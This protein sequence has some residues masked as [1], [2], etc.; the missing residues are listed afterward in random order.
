[1]RKSGTGAVS[2]LEGVERAPLRLRFVAGAVDFLVV[3]GVGIVVA[4]ALGYLLVG[5]VA[6]ALAVQGRLVP[7]GTFVGGWVYFVVMESRFEGQTVGKLGVGLRVVNRDGSAPDVTWASVRYVAK[8]VQVLFGRG[9]LFGVV[10]FDPERRGLHDFLA[11]TVVVV[12]SRGERAG[13]GASG[14]SAIEVE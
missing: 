14:V 8:A 7:V 11:G 4:Q 6:G 9:L 1:M 13:G 5:E 12:A 3:T 2:G 10:V